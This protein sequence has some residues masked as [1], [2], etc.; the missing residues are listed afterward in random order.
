MYL[1]RTPADFSSREPESW[2]MQLLS[3]R[4]KNPGNHD[5]QAVPPYRGSPFRG[6]SVREMMSIVQCEMPRVRSKDRA[7]QPRAQL[8]PSGRLK[9]CRRASGRI[10]SCS[11]WRNCTAVD[12]HRAAD[13]EIVSDS[14]ICLKR[15]TLTEC[16]CIAIA[17]SS[18][19]LWHPSCSIS[20]RDTA[21]HQT[22]GATP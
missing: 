4:E 18:S 22:L 10:P 11:R 2:I 7:G 19:G 5:A 21:P 9:R 14:L 20:D 15:S 16:G 13:A 6:K 12:W 17:A 1:A 8:R 3:R